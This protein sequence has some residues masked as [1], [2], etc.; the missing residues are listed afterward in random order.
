MNWRAWFSHPA[1]HPLAEEDSFLPDLCGGEALP[2]V[3]GISVLM[4]LLVAIV[5]TGVFNLTWPVLGRAVLLALWIAF[6]S[7]V[8]LCLAGRFLPAS[9]PLRGILLCYLAILCVAGAVGLAGE[10][11]MAW[12]APGRQFSFYGAFEVVLISAVPAG[13]LLRYLFMRRRLQ[14]LEQAELEARIQ[15]L[16][17]RIR[18]HFLFNSMN[19]IASLIGSDPVKAERAVE[20]LSDLFRRTLTGSQTLIP[21]REELALCRSYLSLEKLRLGDRLAVEWQIGDYG[22]GAQIPCLTLQPVLENAVYHGVQL[23]QEGGKIE[24]AVTRVKDRISIVVRNP[25]NP[26]MQHNKGSKMAI[27]NVKLRLRA[28][29]GR[30]AEVRSEVSADCY[31]T[32]IAYALYGK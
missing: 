18:P 13:I 11:V 4:A 23:L 3:M 21:L 16:Q 12:A 32:H 6:L 5:D 31:T 14:I 20:D 9:Q 22:A 24:V 27:Q 25:L 29:F 30:S 19:V 17:A 8:S 26:R 28:H 15:A 10:Q 2:Q 1:G 7:V